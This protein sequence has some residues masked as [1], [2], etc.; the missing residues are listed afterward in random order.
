MNDLKMRVLLKFIV[1]CLMV[2]PL[3]SLPPIDCQ[4]TCYIYSIL[5]KNSSER[6]QDSLQFV[7]PPLW[8][9]EMNASGL[10]DVS[11]N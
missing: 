11:V 6:T 4:L 9:V 5:W 3:V 8:T 1:G 7:C 10:T 2:F